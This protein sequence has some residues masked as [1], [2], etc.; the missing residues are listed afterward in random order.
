[1]IKNSTTDRGKWI[2]FQREWVVAYVTMK[3][4]FFCFHVGISW[5]DCHKYEGQQFHSWLQVVQTVVVYLGNTL[6]PSWLCVKVV[7]VSGWWWS[8]G[9]MVQI[10]SFEWKDTCVESIIIQNFSTC[11]WFLDMKNCLNIAAQMCQI[12]RWVIISPGTTPNRQSQS[13]LKPWYI[14]RL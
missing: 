3:F 1:M 7:W 8:E 11:F 12:Q 5:K 6:H 9:L 10:G 4:T 2:G 13:T 14:G